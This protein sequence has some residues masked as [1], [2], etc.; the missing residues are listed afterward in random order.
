M[1]SKTPEYQERQL[2]LMR[3]RLVRYGNGELRLSTLI[4]DLD[5]LITAA[6]NPDPVWQRTMRDLWGVLEQVYAVSLDRGTSI[7]EDGHQHINRA[8][9][10]M[11]RA[12]GALPDA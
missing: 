8:V 6:G 9:L 7:D 11:L 2:D 5:A 10:D 12:L 4:G 3:D 1:D